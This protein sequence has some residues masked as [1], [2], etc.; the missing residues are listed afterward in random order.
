[1]KNGII[2]ILPSF[3]GELIITDLNDHYQ[4]TL[5]EVCYAYQQ[6]TV[7]PLSKQMCPIFINLGPNYETLLPQLIELFNPTQGQGIVYLLPHDVID[8]NL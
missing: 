4:R 8:N 2:K 5:L 1:M 7:H 6:S 3:I